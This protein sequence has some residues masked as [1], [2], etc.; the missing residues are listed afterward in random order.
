MI[1]KCTYY[2]AGNSCLSCLPI[3]PPS[4]PLPC[5]LPR[6]LP[7]LQYRNMRRH[8]QDRLMRMEADYR[9]R[10]EARLFEQRR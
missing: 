7:S 4:L 9:K 6:R 3:P 2:P 5:P 1:Q 10:T 8:E